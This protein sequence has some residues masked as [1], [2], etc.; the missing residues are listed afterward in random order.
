MLQFGGSVAFGQSLAP[1]HNSALGDQFVASVARVLGR[2]GLLETLAS[3]QPA[4][5]DH[6][7]LLKTHSKKFKRFFSGRRSPRDEA[8]RS[9]TLLHNDFIKLAI[10]SAMLLYTLGWQGILPFRNRSSEHSFPFS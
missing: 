2:H 9:S 8:G 10:T 5:Q 4:D 3:D 6:T 7:R 1:V